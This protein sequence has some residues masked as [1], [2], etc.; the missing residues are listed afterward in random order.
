MGNIAWPNLLILLY[1]YSLDIMVINAFL[2]VPFAS[3]TVL[4]CF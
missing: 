4:I 1:V 2:V 3:S